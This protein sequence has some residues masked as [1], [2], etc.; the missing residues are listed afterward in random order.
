MVSVGG[1]GPETTDDAW[2]RPWGLYVAVALLIVAVTAGA[3]AQVVGDSGDSSGS[4]TP[5]RSSTEPEPTS[6]SLVGVAGPT[7]EP[8]PGSAPKVR[9]QGGHPLLT[10]VPVGWQLVAVTRQSLSEPFHLVRIV[11]ASGKITAAAGPP[12]L[13]SGGV[14]LVVGARQVLIRPWDCVAGY[15]LPRAGQ[16]QKLTGGP[17]GT[18]GYAFPGPAPDQVWATD[19]DHPRRVRLVGF[20]GT[21][22]G[23]TLRPRT[24]QWAGLSVADGAGGRLVQTSHGAYDLHPSGRQQVTTGTVVAIGTTTWLTRPCPSQD[25][26]EL[27]A[28]N[29]HTGSRQALPSPCPADSRP[30]AAPLSGTISPDGRTAAMFC[31]GS[32]PHPVLY[33]LDLT[34]GRRHHVHVRLQDID[35]G[36]AGLVWSPNSQWLFTIDRAGRLTAID[37]DTRRVRTLATSLPPLSQLATR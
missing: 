11:P 24:D 29:R 36:P 32:T 35:T 16:A 18:C 30:T 9:R 4:A 19:P 21:P 12:L 15:L 33:L 27:T 28:I 31:T 20:D 26:C 8:V 3:V 2:R 14:A 13:S 37:R 25:Q 22:T 1:E 7:R 5:S 6:S 10:G 34:T 17:L 23:V